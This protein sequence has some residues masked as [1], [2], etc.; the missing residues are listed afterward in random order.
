VCRPLEVTKD[1]LISDRSKWSTSVQ[2]RSSTLTIREEEED[3][4]PR[5]VD[6]LVQRLHGPAPLPLSHSE[7]LQLASVA[8]A[9]LEVC[10]DEDSPEI[11]LTPRLSANDVHWTNAVCDT[12]SRCAWP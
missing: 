11:Q 2:T 5:M 10:V 4:P 12:S 1:S 9:V 7:K 8:R 6:D 3:F